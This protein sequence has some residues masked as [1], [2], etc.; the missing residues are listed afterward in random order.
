MNLD[1]ADL[2]RLT[3]RIKPSAQARVLDVLG[4]RYAPRPDG[5]LVVLQSAVN[6]RLGATADDE[7]KAPEP[8]WGALQ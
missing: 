1:A 8:N 3:Q 7:R 6:A 4:I 2:H 5:S